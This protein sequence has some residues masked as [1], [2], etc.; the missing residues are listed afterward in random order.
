MDIIGALSLS[1][2][3]N[4]SVFPSYSSGTALPP[5][6]GF[7]EPHREQA[8]HLNCERIL[9][10][11]S[12]MPPIRRTQILEL[13]ALLEMLPSLLRRRVDIEF[14]VEEDFPHK[15]IAR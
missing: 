7:I 9:S 11:T 2:P 10:A 15:A 12:R 13:H 6:V 3:S 1:I 5:I 4:T 14:C 8:A